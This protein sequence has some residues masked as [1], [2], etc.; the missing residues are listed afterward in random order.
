[1]LLRRMLIDLMLEKN[2]LS[3]AMRGGALHLN[4]LLTPAQRQA[5]EALP[6]VR[7]DRAS[8]LAADKALWRLFEPLAKELCTRSGAVW[9]SAFEGA[10][11]GHLARALGLHI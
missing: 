6:P 8:L 10:T 11:R 4:D 1:G 5:L 2:G 7:A 3:P 9:P